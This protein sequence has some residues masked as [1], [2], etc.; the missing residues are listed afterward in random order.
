MLCLL[1]AAPA[2]HA[3]DIGPDQ[4]VRTTTDKIIEI[5]KGDKAIQSGDM[6][7]I[8]EVAETHAS[9]H[10]DFV[11]MTRLAMGANWKQA[12]P[13][14]QEELVR[15]FRALLLRTY[16][17]ALKE[18]RNQ[19]IDVRPLKIPAGSTDVQVK[20]VVNQPG[21]QAIPIDYDMER[22]PQGWRVYDVTIGGVSLVVNFRS[23]FD[24]EIRKS[25]VDGLVKSI[26]E[27]NRS[28]SIEVAKK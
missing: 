16:A 18:Y 19:T 14:Q 7:R 28:A 2:V 24:A 27:R 22:T 17:V 3:Q 9:P 4:L 1:L 15:Q 21:A 10:F 11:R 20:T 26:A 13:S 8:L 23:S 6:K 5:V 25:G 12:N